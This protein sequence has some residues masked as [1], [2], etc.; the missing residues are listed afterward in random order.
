MFEEQKKTSPELHN[1]IIWIQ[2]LTLA[3]MSVEATVS[4]GAAWMA[5]SPALLAFGGDSAVELLSATVVF[6][7]F[8]SQ[9]RG[10]RAE[11]KAARI[12]GG[13]LFVLAAFVAVASALTLLGHVEAL[14]SHIGIVVLILAAVVMPWLAK[15]KR[16]LSAATGSAA[17]RA[18]AAESA[19][20]GYLA[21]IALGGL[22]INA[23][24]GVSWADPVAALMLL[25]LIAREGWEAMRGKPC[26]C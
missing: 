5:N 14:P 18:D 22:A 12:A 16:R 26:S 13:L 19:V 25:P 1:R 11:Q 10:N 23:I 4:L 21:M 17:L 2:T 7:R 9:S 24:W 8:Y 15:Q 20:C 6:W 3:W